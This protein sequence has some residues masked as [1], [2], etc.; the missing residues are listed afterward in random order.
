MENEKIEGFFN[1]A[2]DDDDK[3]IKILETDHRYRDVK[4][5]VGSNIFI[6]LMCYSKAKTI[7]EILDKNLSG[8]GLFKSS[9]KII[10]PLIAIRTTVFTNF[11][12]S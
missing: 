2:I 11:T 1:L 3:I 5:A 12:N 6:Q 8:Y 10:Y 4:N 7:K 9:L